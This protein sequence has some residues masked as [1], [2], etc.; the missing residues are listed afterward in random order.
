MWNSLPDDVVTANNIDIFKNR[1]VKFWSRQAL[2]FN[3]K[4]EIAGIVGRSIKVT[5]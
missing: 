3:W 5:V 4:V 2:K 1:L